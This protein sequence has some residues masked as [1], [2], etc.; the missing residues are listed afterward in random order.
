MEQKLIDKLKPNKI[1]IEFPKTLKKIIN[2]KK[3]QRQRSSSIF[4]KMIKKSK[5]ILLKDIKVIN[6]KTLKKSKGKRRL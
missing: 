5:K 6:H 2:R 1:Y 3:V 4:Q